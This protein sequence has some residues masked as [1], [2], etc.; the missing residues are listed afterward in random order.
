[1]GSRGSVPEPDDR[2]KRA[3]LLGNLTP[4]EVKGFYL[5]FRKYDKE[6]NGWAKLNTIFEAIEEKRTVF[7]DSLLE[8]LGE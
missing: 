4:K 1:M 6:K 8:L 3:I 7:T 5:I 2:M